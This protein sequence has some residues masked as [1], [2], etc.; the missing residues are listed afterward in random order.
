MLGKDLWDVVDEF[1]SALDNGSPLF[2]DGLEIFEL[3]GFC[4]LLLGK[5][6][7]QSSTTSTATL[8]SI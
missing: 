8:A 6:S 7:Q 2:I 3:L 1:V 4:L 5:A